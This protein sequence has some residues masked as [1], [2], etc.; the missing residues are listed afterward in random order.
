M[1][2]GDGAGIHG[3]SRATVTMIDLSLH[4]LAQALRDFLKRL[5]DLNIAFQVE[6]SSVVKSDGT[7]AIPDNTLAL[8]LV[9]V[10]EERVVKSPSTHIANLNGRIAHINPEIQLNL[11]VL[12]IANF[13]IYKTSLEFLSGAIRFFQCQTSFTPEN[14][15]SMDARIQ[16]LMIHPQNL[17]FEQQNNLWSSLGGKYMPSV[18]FKVGVITIQEALARDEQE[19]IKEVSMPEKVLFPR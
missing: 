1:R 9:N 10:E 14:T 2:G 7:P 19:P 16:R 5:P 18:L 15:P 11:Y 8:T 17:N 12:C 3:E 4:T 6:L 13:S